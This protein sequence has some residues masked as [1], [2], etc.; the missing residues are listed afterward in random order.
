M[1]RLKPFPDSLVGGAWPFLVREL[2][3]LVYS[4]NERDDVWMMRSFYVVI[5]VICPTLLPR[6]TLQGVG[7]VAITG[8]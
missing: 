7:S 8:L 4:V 6:R 1:D 5:L 2:I 3:C